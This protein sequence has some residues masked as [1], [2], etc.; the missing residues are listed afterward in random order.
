MWGVGIQ[1]EPLGSTSLTMTLHC[2]ASWV[3]P[4]LESTEE[5]EEENRSLS[6][7]QSCSPYL[8][9]KWAY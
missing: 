6:P 1:T 2:G 8:S 3:V 7:T 4:C 5:K 9:T